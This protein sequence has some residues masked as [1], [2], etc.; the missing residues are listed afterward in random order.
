MRKTLER[1]LGFRESFEFHKDRVELLAVVSPL[2][3]LHSVDL[4]DESLKLG[5]A[6]IDGV[7]L[8]ANQWLQFV[9]WS[10]LRVDVL[11]RC[12]AASLHDLGSRALAFLLSLHSIAIGGLNKLCLGCFELHC[13]LV[14]LVDFL[15]K[16]LGVGCEPD[17]ADLRAEHSFELSF[18]QIV[19]RD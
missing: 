14:S 10:I 1:S 12:S 7:D 6:P 5:A 19:V 8:L 11:S 4:R 16:L 17:A 18:I 2:V 15:F 3:S 13:S 9:G